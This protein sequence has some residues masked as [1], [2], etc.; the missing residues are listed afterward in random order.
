MDLNW[1]YTHLAY[2]APPGITGGTLALAWLIGLA[3]A[4]YRSRGQHPR[5]SKNHVLA[6]LVLFFLTFLLSPFALKNPSHIGIT[7]PTHPTAANADLFLWPFAALPWVLAAGFLGTIPAMLLA[8]ISG[9][10]IGIWSTHMPAEPL[11]H[12]TLAWGIAWAI[13]QPYGTRFYRALRQPLIATFTAT[14]AYPFVFG[15]GTFILDNAQ[16]APQLDFIFTQALTFTRYMGVSLLF[17]GLLA[18]IIAFWQPK[19]WGYSGEYRPSPLERSLIYRFSFVMITLM[20]AM[21]LSIVV[22]NWK[23]A[24]HSA[25]GF[26]LK[27]LS[28]TARITAQT[29]PFFVENGKNAI[30]NIA[31]DPRINAEDPNEISAYLRDEA[32]GNFLFLSLILVDTE[33]RTIAATP[34]NSTI[35]TAEMAKMRLFAATDAPSTYGAVFDPTRQCAIVAFYAPVI[36]ASG[37]KR[38]LVGHTT[39][40]ENPYNSAI[41][42][43]LDDLTSLEGGSVILDA[44]HD[45]IFSTDHNLEWVRNIN[46]TRLQSLEPT[47]ANVPAATYAPEHTFMEGSYEVIDPH[48][49]RYLVH[50]NHASGTQWVVLTLAPTKQLQTIALHNALPLAGIVTLLAIVGILISRSLVLI[51]TRS[52]RSLTAAAER[53]AS[54]QLS[55]PLEVTSVDEV[56]QLRRAFEYMRQ[57]LQA[58]MSELS[59]LLHTSQRIAATLQVQEAADAVLAAAYAPECAA[60]RVALSPEALP[61]DWHG[62]YPIHFGRGLAAKAYESLDDQLLALA[63]RQPLIRFSQIP[64]GAGL[65]LPKKPSPPRALLA[66]ALRYETRFLG[67]LYIVY[68]TPHTFSDEE[69]RYLSALGL[70]MAMAAYTARLYFMAEVRHQRLLAV[71][72]AS[73][74]PILVTDN[75]ERLILANV[76]ARSQLPIAQEMNRPLDEVT[77]D[78]A[79]L[80]LLRREQHP[81]Y[82]DEITINNRVYFATVSSVKSNETEIGRVCI[83][84]DITHFKELDA[85]KSEFVATVSHDLRAPL[86]LINGYLTMLEMVGQINERQSHYIA[87]IQHGVQ[88]MTQLVNNLLDLGRIEAGV[89]LQ[90]Q[91]VSVLDIIDEVAKRWQPHAER[92]HI[93]LKT[94]IAPDTPPLIEAD[95]VLLDRALHNLVDNAIKYTPSG[96]TVVILGQAEGHNKVLLGVQDSGVGISPIDQP[97]LFEKFFRITRRDAPREKGS[98]LGLAIVKSIVERHHG[99][100]WVESQ[101]GEGSTFFIELPLRQPE[102]SNKS[103]TYGY[104]PHN[105]SN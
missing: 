15:A 19:P 43:G 12:A 81:P 4:A 103:H 3:Y 98:G 18:Q 48:G 1:L 87:Q 72:D 54:G 47:P 23:L 26:I 69:T 20:L 104:P 95:P 27:Q 64:K 63:R 93:T 22:S 52:L 97:R 29:L 101:L 82:S 9:A 77:T 21:M 55:Q 45:V 13:W 41:I 76:A 67:V 10:I 94:E 16:L 40:K 34:P 6:F 53:I 57:R 5:W 44:D 28:T 35:T 50:I 38:V 8:F 37:E 31:A 75:Q 90:L 91:L 30:L 73:P 59:R 79:L 99:R 58:R 86:T 14:L 84:R 78:K 92:K 25:R 105:G 70:Q 61:D 85:L 60:V 36:T 83:L 32:K 96:G 33:G 102:E 89:G 24:Q 65:Q 11:I 46:T 100:V 2:V 71:L 17:A 62:E 74:D 7:L 80:S 56:G 66:V 42:A 68:N 49:Q 51:L 39:F 88:N